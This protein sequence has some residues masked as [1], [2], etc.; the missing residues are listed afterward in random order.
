MSIIS[1][2]SP[3][4]GYFTISIT[5]LSVYAII[6]TYLIVAL[7]AYADNENSLIPSR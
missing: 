3:L 6:V 1:L 5:N 2:V 4:F 7:H